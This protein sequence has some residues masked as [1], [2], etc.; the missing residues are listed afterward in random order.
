MHRAF[1]VGEHQLYTDVFSDFCLR[2][3]TIALHLEIIYG[4][5]HSVSND[6]ERH[7]RGMMKGRGGGQN[8]NVRGHKRAAGKSA[9]LL[10][11][12]RK[13]PARRLPRPEAAVLAPGRSYKTPEGF[14]SSRLHAS[15][16]ERKRPAIER[17][18]E[19]EKR[20]R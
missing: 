18:R 12:K 6:F 16:E 5:C 17:E 15:S 13:P 1:R 2:L 9:C 4:L 8:G 14:P 11:T 7:C 19:R 20:R 10:L 3:L